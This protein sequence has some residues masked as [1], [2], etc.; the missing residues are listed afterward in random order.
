ML[1]GRSVRLCPCVGVADSLELA[2]QGRNAAGLDYRALLRLFRHD[3]LFDRVGAGVWPEEFLNKHFGA[4]WADPS[5]EP[6]LDAMA[7]AVEALG[8]KRRHALLHRPE[9]VMETCMPLKPIEGDDAAAY[10]RV[11]AKKGVIDAETIL[12]WL[13]VV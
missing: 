9:L 13:Q 5:R 11:K 12:L 3:G 7:S 2:S 4:C 6:D 1:T 8:P 10:Q